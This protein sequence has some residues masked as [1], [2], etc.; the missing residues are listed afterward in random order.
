MRT[1]ARRATET[2]TE[3]P[4]PSHV[5][6]K[7]II[8][9]KKKSWI[10]A[11]SLVSIFFMVLLMNTYFN[12]SSG[13][14]IN[15][16]GETLSDTYYLSGPDPY[17][18]LR[19]V[20]ETHETGEYPYYG[21]QNPDPLL[22]YPLGRSGSRPPLLNMMALGFSRLLAP[23]MD[24][25]DAV[26]YSM[27]FVP[28]L[29]GALLIFP[30]YFIG[31]TLFGRTE[32]VIAA[33]LIAIIPIHIGSGHG[34][35]YGLFDHD[36]FNLFLFFTTFFFLI[37]S[38]TNKSMKK[39]L[40][41]FTKGDI[42]AVLGGICVASLAMTWVE[43][44]FIFTV[45]ALYAIVQMLIDI[46]R[47]QMNSQVVRSAIILLF[48]GYLISL[49]VISVRLG[50][51][52]PDLSLFLAL[53]V[54]IFGLIYLLVDRLKIPWLLSLPTIFIIGALT[55]IFLYFVRDL[56]ATF[57][58]LKPLSGIADILY[59][60]G[61]YGDKVDATIAEAGTYSISRTVMSY[62]PA[63]YWLS[64]GGFVFLLY[65]YIKQK[66]RRDYL[67]II[68]LF[69]INVW[70][71]STA[72][73]FL[74][75]HVPLITIL[76]AWIIWFVIVRVDYKQM[77]KNIRNAGGGFKGLRKGVKIYH[78][79]GILFVAFIVVMPNSLLAFDAAI[80]SAVT[81]N[82]TSNLKIDYFGENHQGAFGSSSYKEQYWVD[83]FS[84]L[85]QQDGAEID[86]IDRPAII[87]WWDYGF[88][89]VAIG[90]HPTVADNFQ[91]GIP[92]AANFHTAKNEKEGVAIFIVR[93]LEG[94]A[95]ENE[96]ELSAN[97]VAVLTEHLGEN[98]SDD[99]VQWIEN[100]ETSPSYNQPIG[101]QYDEDLSKTLLIGEQYPQNAFYQDISYLINET[102]DDE[103]VTW[104]Y[105]DVQ[106]ITGYSIRY[107]G[108][109]GYDTQIFN[110]FAFLS[111]KSLVLH[112]LRTGGG[113]RL[114]NAED[115]FVVVKYVGYQVNA[116]G[117]PGPEGEWTTEELNELTDTERRRIVITDTKTVD[118]PDYFNTMFYR[119][120]V[121][122]I[123]TEFE[124]QIF[125][126][127]C[128]GMRHFTAE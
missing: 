110:I 47:N 126:L 63:L 86:P 60:S 21:S 107:Y 103:G 44:R 61:I 83:A 105:H 29:F 104:L 64:W 102:L 70:L 4:A 118:K 122:D 90:E 18:N 54:L 57:T 42:Y 26:G 52:S 67:F 119:T 43:A 24:E 1:R 46:F 92:P 56:S 38:M 65:Q 98:N 16:D 39:L 78:V 48:S 88:Y 59:G 111:D 85:L 68:V 19:L 127:P 40:G 82:G 23:F 91:D 123:P 10:V 81:Q 97:V 45:I 20:K 33:M 87:S 128:W 17:Y 51:F 50:G 25:G 84:W 96:G 36:S 7:R 35:A 89:E 101:S 41:L 32:G 15:P 124:N 13:L 93:L 120:Y 113:E 76:A 11:I 100:P 55:A 72:G 22:N 115:D 95:R 114:Y 31:K 116:D 106:E 9:V 108:V 79:L 53:G 2:V 74:N 66:G 117:T 37:K 30:V 109:E 73:R 69:L 80:P 58:F 3:T 94:N 5:K 62:G 8:Q 125:Q 12:L 34:S 71:A 121:G 27:Q 49:P 77:I 6:P 112:A 28:A 75:D 99:V 14:A